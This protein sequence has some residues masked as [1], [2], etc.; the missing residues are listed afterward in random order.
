MTTQ[1]KPPT[2]FADEYLRTWTEPDQQRRAALIDMIWASDGMLSVS[3][4]GIT[5]RGVAQITAHITR[6]HDDMIATKGLRFVYD[7]EVVSGDATLLRWSML[8]PDGDVA[9][10]GVD[11]VFHNTQ[12][13]V[14][15]VHMFMGID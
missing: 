1:K 3:S 14:T 10:R 11:I 8:A 4:L 9:G 5:L 2:G 15:A 7:Q 6:V 13:Q 12:G